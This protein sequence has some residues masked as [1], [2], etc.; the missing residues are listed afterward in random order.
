MVI[1]LHN[2][3][4]IR[5]LRCQRT[6]QLFMIEVLHTISPLYIIPNF[7]NYADKPMQVYPKLPLQS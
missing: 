1:K 7:R 6:T 2:A 3:Q 4:S 5:V